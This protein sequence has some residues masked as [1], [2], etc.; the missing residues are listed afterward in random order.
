[1]YTGTL[2][3]F[4]RIECVGFLGLMLGLGVWDAELFSFSFKGL[5]LFLFI[6]F[7]KIVP[8]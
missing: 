3:A 8:S 4:P 5:K 2:K 7:F 6:Y 1:M